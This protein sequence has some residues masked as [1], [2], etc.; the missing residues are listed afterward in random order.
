MKKL[1]GIFVLGLIVN[2]VGC[3]DDDNPVKS[4]NQDLLVGTWM[5]EDEDAWTYRSDGTFVDWDEDEGTWSLVGD[6]FIMAYNDEAY[7]DETYTVISVTDTEFTH[8][9]EGDTYVWTRDADGGDEGGE[10]FARYEI[11]SL[12]NENLVWADSEYP[13]IKTTLTR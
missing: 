4:S 10:V 6:Q 11:T 7:D 9:Y 13:D 8:T 5:D 2:V 1:F 12:S 3:G